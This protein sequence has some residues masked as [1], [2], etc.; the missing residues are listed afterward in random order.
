MDGEV[1]EVEVGEVKSSAFQGVSGMLRRETCG[2]APPPRKATPP[3]TRGAVHPRKPLR[4]SEALNHS[5]R[6][7]LKR[8]SSIELQN[9]N[10]FVDTSLPGSAAS[11]KMHSVS[12]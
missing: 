9:R 6:V 1:E 10:P 2:T 12:C 5:Q 7:P 11:D 8:S 3:V 4:R